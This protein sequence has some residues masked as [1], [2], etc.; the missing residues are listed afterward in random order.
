MTCEELRDDY[1]LYALG[2]SAQPV[3]RELREHLGRGCENCL[4]GIRSAIS[5]TTRLSLAVPLADP[6]ARLRKRV[7]ALSNPELVEHRRGI[8]SVVWATAAGLLAVLLLFL[9]SGQTRLRNEMARVQT[10]SQQR[11]IELARLTESLSLLDDPDSQQV[12]F[13]QGAP[14]PPRGKVFVNAKRGVVFTASNLSPVA[15]GRTYE[16]WLIPKSGNPVAAGV[17]K[18]LPDG[19][20]L[21]VLQGALPNVDL[22]AIAVTEEPDGGVTQPTT[23]PFIIAA[24]QPSVSR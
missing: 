20:A 10:E 4:P 8:W 9:A 19:S 17:F 3:T 2:S 18:P 15:A 13:G 22:A 11:Q 23:K 24:L 7:L 21:H 6:P 14:R 12:I 16:M 1:E 5:L